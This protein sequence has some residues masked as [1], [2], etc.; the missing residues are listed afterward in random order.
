M[1][2]KE[3]CLGKE[4]KTVHLTSGDTTLLQGLFLEEKKWHNSQIR[5]AVNLIPVPALVALCLPL[6][7]VGHEDS[8]PVTFRALGAIPGSSGSKKCTVQPVFQSHFPSF[9]DRN[10]KC[11]CALRS[12]LYK[13][14]QE[15]NKCQC[16]RAFPS[17]ILLPSCCADST[18]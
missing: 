11:T 18:Y 17:D 9:S 2:A 12:V 6:A 5:L 8:I 4:E 14:P 15:I 10:I 3:F 16:T 7:A 1:E 13:Y